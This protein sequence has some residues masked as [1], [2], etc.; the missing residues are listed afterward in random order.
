MVSGGFDSQ[1]LPISDV[2]QWCPGESKWRLISQLKMPR[3][4]HTATLLKDG[5]I[6]VA[7]GKGE[8]ERTLDS[9]E[10]SEPTAKR[11]VAGPRQP[12]ALHRHAATRLPEVC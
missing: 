11:W 1:G 5:R 8:D 3:Y 12:F 2:E 4:D 7:G 10:I 9:S 6:I